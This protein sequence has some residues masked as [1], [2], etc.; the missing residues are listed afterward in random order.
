MTEIWSA[1]SLNDILDSLMKAKG[2]GPNLPIDQDLLKQINVNSGGRENIGLIRNIKEGA[3]LVWPLGLKGADF[4]SERASID[5]LLPRSVSQALHGQVDDGIRTALDTALRG[6]QTKLSQDVNDLTPS[7]YIEAK[8]FL[9]Q[10]G[11]AIA[12]LGDR[13]VANYFT[14][15][16]AP[17]GKTVEELVSYM[18]DHGLRFAPA[19]AGDEAAY[20]ALHH[21]LASYSRGVQVSTRD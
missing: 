6:L 21:Y 12:A 3:P 8:R 16:F 11:D 19:V 4:D 14:Q 15:K 13:N 7:Q 5:S 18:A 9:N 2:K 1:K 10:L 20:L 17:Q